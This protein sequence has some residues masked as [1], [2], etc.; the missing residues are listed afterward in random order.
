MVGG[1]GRGGGVDEGGRGEWGGGGGG[2]EGGGGGGHLRVIP[3]GTP[4]PVIN[5]PKN[6]NDVESHCNAKA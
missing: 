5:R 3:R 1:S 4:K 2:G 6:N